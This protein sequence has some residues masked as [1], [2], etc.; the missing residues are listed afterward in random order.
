MGARASGGSSARHALGR[1]LQRS[2]IPPLLRALGASQRN[3]RTPVHPTAAQSAWLPELQRVVAT[4]NETFSASFRDIGCAGDITLDTADG[5]DYA[6]F[7][8]QVG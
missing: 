5:E 7:A 1:R 8:I 6:K 4:V 2:S 3:K